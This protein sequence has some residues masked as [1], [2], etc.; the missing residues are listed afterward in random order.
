MKGITFPAVAAFVPA[1][2]ALAPLLEPEP[3]TATPPIA[4]AIAAR[5]AAMDA[6]SLCLRK[7]VFVRVMVV[8]LRVVDRWL[9]PLCDETL[10]PPCEDPE[11][12]P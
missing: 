3:A 9:I 6:V 7:N 2:V 10:G 8:H 1:V 4:T 5:P 11:N 12:G